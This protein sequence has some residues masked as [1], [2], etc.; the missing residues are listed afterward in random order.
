MST[1]KS[2]VY[3]RCGDSGLTDAFDKDGKVLK[4][5]KDSQIFDVIGT[6]D[7]LN[8]HIGHARD[9]L[10]RVTRNTMDPILLDVQ[11][12]IFDMSSKLIMG[13][14]F[15]GGAEKV[16]K[17]ESCID[18]LDVQTLPVKGFI[19]PGGSGIPAS[20]QLHIARTVCRRAERE[21]LKYTANVQRDNEILM[22]INRLSDLLFVCAKWCNSANEKPET[23][24]KF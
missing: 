20:S 7:E 24:V 5:P 23:L 19:I 16:K 3:T 10:D 9:L 18:T 8:S 13:K 22:Y 11:T 1:K 4:I 14:P 12:C 17:L 21:Y 15:E 6:L 2:V